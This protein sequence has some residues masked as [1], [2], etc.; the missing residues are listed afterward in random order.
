MTGSSLLARANS[1]RSR[2]NESSAGV[3]P[4]LPPWASPRG[5]S[6]AT[7][8]VLGFGARA[9]QVEHLVADLVELEAQVHQHLG[10]HA[11]VLAEQA[12]QQVLGADVVVIE[13]AGLFDGV[14][15]HLL[16]PRGLRQ[17]CP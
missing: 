5:G 2:P 4:R 17:A 9:E 14:F 11:V 6:A 7:G 3:R 12:E 10:R 8:H 16:G 1:V 15:D 13:V